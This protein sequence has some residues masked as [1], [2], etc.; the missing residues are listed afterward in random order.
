MIRMQAFTPL[1]RT[2]P[3]S[4]S[5]PM[6]FRH[7]CARIVSTGARPLV[8]LH[9]GRGGVQFDH[10]AGLEADGVRLEGGVRLRGVQMIVPPG[11]SV[12]GAVPYWGGPG[13][14]LWDAISERLPSAAREQIERQSNIIMPR[15][16][17]ESAIS[18]LF[19]S[20]AERGL[21][22]AGKRVPLLPQAPFV[23]LDAAAA[24][25][26]DVDLVTEQAEPRGGCAGAVEPL[27]MLRL[28]TAKEWA[29]FA[30]SPE[31]RT[32]R[33]DIATRAAYS[34][35]ALGAW[36]KLRVGTWPVDKPFPAEKDDLAAA[37]EHF[38]KLG[39]REEFREI[40]T[41]K[42][43]ESWRKPGPRRSR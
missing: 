27:T 31:A 29:P 30:R 20:A 25:L 9:D 18:A 7:C 5:Q 12:A 39:T 2:A 38:G 21:T 1:V 33:S 37:G 13:R 32:A 14:G 3:Q 40:R 22:I 42:T 6:P 34:T 16:Q 8:L 19:K 4:Q 26:L 35:A 24:S 10:V 43:P 36:F 17:R 15:G 41:L 11:I 23:A 28:F